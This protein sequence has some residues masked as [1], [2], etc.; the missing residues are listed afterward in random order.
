MLS[1]ATR[2]SSPMEPMAMGT[3]TQPAHFQRCDRE[4]KEIALAAY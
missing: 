2:T 1:L 4:R 3:S